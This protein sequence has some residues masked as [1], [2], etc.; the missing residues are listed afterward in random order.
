MHKAQRKAKFIVSVTKYLPMKC[1]QRRWLC[2]TN[3]IGDSNHLHNGCGEELP[4][5]MQRNLTK[6]LNWKRS[7]GIIGVYLNGTFLFRYICSYFIK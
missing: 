7:I 6:N 2:V 3:A 1:L 4:D 5:I